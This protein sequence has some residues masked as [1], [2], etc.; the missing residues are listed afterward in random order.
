MSKKHDKNPAAQA[1]A[2]APTANAPAGHGHG[3]GAHPAHHP[4][5]GPTLSTFLTIWITLGLLTV[6]EIF[7]PQVYSAEWNQNT[8][9]LLLV[10]LA[11][12]KAMLVAAFFMH[13]K[14]ESKWVRWIAMMPAYMGLFAVLLMVEEA[15]RPSLS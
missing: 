13:L 5:L 4:H 1:P 12:G 6:V 7:V 9:M 15:F 8:K 2:H 10:I 11:T 3:G 14:W